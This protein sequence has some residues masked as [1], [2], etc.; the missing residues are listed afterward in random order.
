[1][2][3]SIIL[4]RGWKFFARPIR[5]EIATQDEEGSCCEEPEVRENDWVTENLDLLR[6][7]EENR[8]ILS[9]LSLDDRRYSKRVDFQRLASLIELDRIWNSLKV[10]KTDFVKSGN[11]YLDASCNGYQHVSSLLRDKQLARLSNVTE[12]KSGPMDLYS[13]VAKEANKIGRATIEEFLRRLT[14]ERTLSRSVLTRFSRG[15]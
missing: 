10:A 13:E 15:V 9:E 4:W 2:C 8:E 11:Q 12:S 6:E 7:I 5:T 3:T 14:S 1:M